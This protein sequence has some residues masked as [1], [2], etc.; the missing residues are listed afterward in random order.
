VAVFGLG[1]AAAV[2]KGA[3]GI[4]NDPY[5]GFGFLI[6]FEG[7]IAGGFSEVSGLQIETTIET[8]REG[9][10]N[11]YQHKLAGATNYPSNLTLKSGLTDLQLMWLW[12]DDVRNG[13]IKRRNGSIYL[14]DRKGLPAMWWDVAGAYPVK[15]SGPELRA[16][17]NS[18]A[19]ESVELV[20]CGITKPVESNVMSA[21]RLAAG[22]AMNVAGR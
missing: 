11:D 12:Y 18:V 17:S 10:L 2:G 19:V 16:D 1:A 3:L 21:G 5:A 15:W 14:L 4:R 6:E 20:H 7:L 9:G 22:A 8:Y 13:K